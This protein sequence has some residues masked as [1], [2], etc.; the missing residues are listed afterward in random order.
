MMDIVMTLAVVAL[1]AVVVAVRASGYPRPM[2][3]WLWVALAEYLLCSVYQFFNG[4]DANG[5]REAGTE[6]A[7]FLDADFGWAA[8]EVLAI[9]V[10][11]PSAFDE[12]A[13]GAGTN[14][15]SMCAAAAWLLFFVRG[16]PYAAQALVAGL[17]MLGAVA[18]YDACHD[19]YP[20]AS[21][22]RVFAATVLFP[23]V[24]FWT[25]ALHKEAFCL[26][27]I[28]LVLAGWRAAYKRRIRALFYA[29]IGM[30]FVVMFRA[31]ALPPLLLGLVLHFVLDRSR[32]ARGGE[33]ILVRPIYVV[34]GLGVMVVGMILVGR[35]SPE[36][37]VDRI[38]DSVVA[39]QRAWTA[40]ADSA[41]GAGGSAF[42]INQP[43]T[44][45]LGGQLVRAP[46]SLVNAL[47]RPQLFDVT[48]PPVLVSAL[49]MTTLTWMI[50]SALRR[51]GI[52][53][54]LL[55]IRRSPFLVMCAVITVCGCTF[56][57]LTTRNFGT[58]ARYRVPF[59]PFYGIL[60]AGLTQRTVGAL[61]TSR[62]PMLKAR[63]SRRTAG[64]TVAPT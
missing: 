25:S 58:L 21:P 56:V 30:I 38:S 27:G 60:L 54:T 47:F 43:V 3:R 45:S 62:P 12:A 14:T 23:S 7:K 37:A 11:Q 36:L 55:R 24:A 42:D 1:L 53:G 8:G 61:S 10:H 26:M 2:R 51:L 41:D 57:G 48:S 39:Q 34:I 9:L 59:L 16:S 33:V 29:P 22:L 49:E 40:L 64:T 13:F 31:P 63:S 46:L 44:Q 28:G 50:L 52:G 5:Y 15:G 32:K 6:L 35:I 20:E 18:V 17:S 19:A 4:A